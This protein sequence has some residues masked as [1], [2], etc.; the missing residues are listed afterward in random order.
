[1]PYS[2]FSD[3]FCGRWMCRLAGLGLLL[4]AA[5]TSADPLEDRIPAGMLIEMVD[6]TLCAPPP[7]DLSDAE[8]I[9]M[10]NSDDP[11]MA[12][13]ITGIWEQGGEQWRAYGQGWFNDGSSGPVVG[14]MIMLRS[15]SDALQF[16]CLVLSPHRDTLMLDGDGALV[17]PDVEA[18]DGDTFMAMGTLEAR[19]G[20]IG[21]VLADSGRVT[22]EPA[23]D[24]TLAWRMT[25]DGRLLGLN[26]QPLDGG[27]S[28]TL[29]G[30]LDRDTA[31][32]VADW[33][34]DDLADAAAPSVDEAQLAA[35]KELFLQEIRLEVEPV[36]TPDT[37]DLVRT[38]V[39]RYEYDT[40]SSQTDDSGWRS[41]RKRFFYQD[42]EQLVPFTRPSSDVDLS[43]FFDG[44]LADDF[45]L[46][47]DSA[48]DFRH[49]LM[50]LAGED[51]FE[52][53]DV[54]LDNI[55]NFRPDEWI[56]F[57]G[58]FFGDYKAF[59]AYTDDQGR[60]ERVVYRLRQQ[61]AS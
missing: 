47:E 18:I 7:E 24:D 53:E 1:M 3:S 12:P 61:P 41:S 29:E 4:V 10:L 5:P 49:L 48:D 38:T 9:G 16:L 22:F 14:A 36:L 57:T 31:L 11:D 60:P 52:E 42:E 27:L 17:G 20:E 44:L 46:D 37:S 54:Q 39:Y 40:F 51:F 19:E 6:P 23:G 30:E 59:V 33:G 2:A 43:A 15:Q 25:F 32:R 35:V 8:L 55:V 45:V 50:T 26:Q 13:P 28:V 58:T 34:S 56:F 21:E